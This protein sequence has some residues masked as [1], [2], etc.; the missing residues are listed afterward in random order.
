MA[1]RVGTIHKAFEAIERGA[2]KRTIAK[3]VA[4]TFVKTTGVDSLLRT[5]AY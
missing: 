2:G 1:L 5:E 3:D 4:R